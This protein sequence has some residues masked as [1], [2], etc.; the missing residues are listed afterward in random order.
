[1]PPVVWPVL[2]EQ[3]LLRTTSKW[4]LV[5]SS[6]QIFACLFHLI[7]FQ[8]QALSHGES[9]VLPSR[10]P[11]RADRVPMTLNPP[12]ANLVRTATIIPPEPPQVVISPHTTNRHRVLANAP[13]PVQTPA[14]PTTEVGNAAHGVVTMRAP[15]ASPAR[16]S[17]V[18]PRS[19]WSR[20]LFIFTF[21]TPES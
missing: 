9:L 4:P 11:S 3:W 12:D 15:S 10:A 17:T 19:N 18:S 16:P 21:P 7:F 20:L 14:P 1:M 6:V 13:A 2:R 5:R 8:H